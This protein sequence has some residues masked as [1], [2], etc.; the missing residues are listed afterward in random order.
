[1]TLFKGE[2][3]HFCS[4][5]RTK[6]IYDSFSNYFQPL[7][8]IR[9]VSNSYPSP[10]SLYW[11]VWPL[12]MFKQNRNAAL[13]LYVYIHFITLKTSVAQTDQQEVDGVSST[14]S[15]NWVDCFLYCHKLPS[16][17]GNTRRIRLH[18]KTFQMYEIFSTAMIRVQTKDTGILLLPCSHCMFLLS[19]LLV[20]FGPCT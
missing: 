1:M 7:I 4:T 13:H 10:N 12:G 3:C 8:N 18:S 11:C 9:N 5:S 2:I 19:H 17:Q 15:Q 6:Q 20:L 14:E 16:Q